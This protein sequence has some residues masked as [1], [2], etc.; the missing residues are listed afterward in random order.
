MSGLKAK[1]IIRAHGV[2]CHTLEALQAAVT[3]DW[4]DVLLA[5]INHTGSHMD[6][7]PAKVM[8]ELKKAH[9]RGA[10]VIG[11]KIFGV[12]DLVADDQ[13]QAS[14]EYS[15]RSGNIDTMTIGFEN[16]AQIDDTITRINR[17]IAG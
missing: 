15:W 9:D 12:G 7:K 4:V 14:L 11:M 5:R 8:P 17:I 1:G 3:D 2:S 16:K 13:R 10:G 6:D